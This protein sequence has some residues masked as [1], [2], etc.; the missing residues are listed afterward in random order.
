MENIRVLI[1]F[2]FLISLQEQAT[3]EI[4]L[5]KMQ[6]SHSFWFTAEGVTFFAALLLDPRPT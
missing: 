5:M 1:F 2:G 4:T 3:L 6:G